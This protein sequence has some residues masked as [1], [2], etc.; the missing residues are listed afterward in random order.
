MVKVKTAYGFPITV[1][2]ID[3]FKFLK[4]FALLK[5]HGYK[6]NPNIVGCD[7]PGGHTSGSNHHIGRACDNQWARNKAPAYMYHVGALIRQAGLYDGCSFRDCGHVEAVRG[8][9]NRMPNLRVALEKFKSQLLT[10]VASV[11]APVQAVVTAAITPVQVVAKTTATNLTN[12]ALYAYNE[13]LPEKPANLALASLGN[14][15]EGSA[16]QEA[17]LAADAF[18]LDHK[19][20]LAV[21]QVESDFSCHQ[22][23][24]RY[25]G[26]FQLS[27]YEFNANLGG[28][29]IID[30][31][32]NAMAAASKFVTEKIL[33]EHAVGRE[34][35]FEDMYLVHQQGLG[36]AV[37]HLTHPERIAWKSMCT[38]D[39]GQEKGAAWC[40]KAIWGNTLPAL[41]ARA[42]SV[43][44]LTSGDFVA[45][46]NKR[47]GG[48]IADVDANGSSVR[49][50]SAK[51]TH[52]ASA[53]RHH[54][55]H[56]VRHRHHHVM[57]ASR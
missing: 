10:D 42:G 16:R 14:A 23:T 13:Y 21:A 44:K 2:P 3:A 32:R 49:T 30:C 45:H 41:K 20:I 28:D 48:L 29:G 56:Y 36:G 53:K 55:H 34:A 43:E 38:T 40:R 39:E 46:W 7:S 54:H 17:L 6:V 47:V 27:S 4:F 26:L 19:F 50:A 15:P 31:R 11:V 37:A 8:L 52:T 9:H 57:M 22:T 24:G 51:P 5:A 18:G 35:T 1:H 33:F 12:F 25:K